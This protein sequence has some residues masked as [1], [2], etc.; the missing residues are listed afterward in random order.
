MEKLLIYFLTSILFV[1]FLGLIFRSSQSFYE[2]MQPKYSKEKIKRTI[3]M[4]MLGIFYLVI[5]LTSF[6]L[7]KWG[8]NIYLV[9]A[10]GI[11][12]LVISEVIRRKLKK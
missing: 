5:I 2:V 11:S 4:I 7:I 12:V 6:L 9:S 1:F 3:N 8:E 10:S